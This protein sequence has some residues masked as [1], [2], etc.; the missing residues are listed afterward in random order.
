MK[1]IMILPLLIMAC[2]FMIGCSVENEGCEVLNDETISN[3]EAQIRINEMSDDYGVKIK[4]TSLSNAMIWHES[5][6][7]LIESIIR[8]FSKIKGKYNLRISKGE[9]GKLHLVQVRKYSRI[10]RLTL[11]EEHS[12]DGE[13]HYSW[14]P[15][16]KDKTSVYVGDFKFD[17]TYSALWIVNKYGW[18]TWAE[19]SGSISRVPGSGGAENENKIKDEGMGPSSED[20]SPRGGG[21]I[22]FDGDLSYYVVVGNNRIDLN[23]SYTGI[24]SVVEDTIKGN[25]TTGSIDWYEKIY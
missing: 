22:A 16:V 11:E 4:T 15:D 6:L 10:T 2:S 13:Q 7:K 14:E 5:D 25:Y 23:I 20:W 3:Q 1:K 24:C 9:N 19:S 21:S 17:C 18:A 8:G 12:S